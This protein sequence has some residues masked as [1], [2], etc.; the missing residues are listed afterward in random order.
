MPAK[1]DSPNRRRSIAVPNQN[2]PAFISRSKRRAHSIVSGDRLSPLARARRSLAPRKSILKASINNV[3]IN[4]SQQASQS[5]TQSSQSLNP[6]DPNT[7]QA[8]D[9]TM[10]LQS[11]QDN[12]IQRSFARRVSF[13]AHATVRLFQKQNH[14]DNTNSTGTPPSSPSSPSANEHGEPSRTPH[15]NDENDYPGARPNGRRSSL[16]YSIAQNEDMDLT[17]IGP[18]NFDQEG[19]AIMDEEIEEDSFADDT[20]AI[21]NVL[22]RRRSSVA[23][24]QFM[25]PPDN[26]DVSVTDEV[27][28]SDDAERSRNQSMEF[29]IPINRP[30]RPA[31]RDEAWLALRRVT[32]SGSENI[33]DDADM[34]ISFGHNAQEDSYNDDDASCN[35]DDENQTMNITKVL[36]WPEDK[37]RLS[38]G[39]ES[40]ME[41]SEVYGPAIPA[42]ETGPRP[43]VAAPFDPQLSSPQQEGRTSI[44]PR[45]EQ[46]PPATPRPSVFQPP[47]NDTSSGPAQTINNKIQDTF[48]PQDSRPFSFTAPSPVIAR[49]SSPSKIPV[50]RPT[51]TAAFAPPVSKSTPKKSAT[52]TAP[53]SPSHSNKRPRP[54]DDDGTAGEAD[55]SIDTPS[56][57]KR[58][59]MTSKWPGSESSPTRAAASPSIASVPKPKPLSPSKKAP[60][61]G[62][63][64]MASSSTR[65]TTSLRRPSGYFARRKSLAAG[66]TPQ[67]ASDISASSDPKS[68]NNNQPSAG[69]KTGLGFRR[70]SVSSGSTDAWQRFDKN[71]L[72]V[73]GDRPY[74]RPATQHR[75]ENASE[76]QSTSPTGMENQAALA[77]PTSQSSAVSSS[78]PKADIERQHHALS[79]PSE[80]VQSVQQ[81]VSVDLSN[82][83]DDD[84]ANEAN[85]EVVETANVDADA[86]TGH[87][88]EILDNKIPVEEETPAIS[89]EQFFATTGIRF[90]DQLTAPRR[91][92]HHS[93]YPARQVREE[94]DISLTEYFTA[95][96][97]DVP[98]LEL[99]TRVARDL[100]AWMEQSRTV[101]EQAEEE[102]AKITPELF[103]EYARADEESQVE[104]LHQLN[105][106]R[107]NV[108]GQAKSDWYDWKLQWVQGLKNIADK[109]FNALEDD[110]KIL[111]SIK[112]KADEIVPSLE[113]EYENI[114]RE[115]EQERTEVAEIEAS[116]QEYLNELKNA[117]SEQN[118]EVEALQAE[119]AEGR[120]RLQRLEERLEEIENQKSEAST[121]IAGAQR[122]LL[123]HK[124]STRAEV[125]RLKDELDALE[126][127]HMFRAT[128]ISPELFQYI[129]NSQFQVTIP[130]RNYIPIVTQ[131]DISRTKNLRPQSKD[132]FPRLSDFFL[133]MA[134]QQIVEGED[135]TVKQ[136]VHRLADY[137]SSCTQ[138][139]S[140][141]KLLSIKYPI[142]I[143]I[144]RPVN[145]E[146]LPSFKAHAT[147]LF[148]TVKAKAIISFVFSTA[149]FCF[150]PL[151]LDSMD[152][153]VKVAY[154]SI[155]QSNILKRVVDRFSQATPGNNHAC[156]LDACIEAQEAYNSQNDL[157]IP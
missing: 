18:I 46:L 61:Q 149:T 75:N 10:N 52:Q 143:E 155:D 68:I 108:R 111:E 76:N 114:M 151:T 40:N 72:P 7:T 105:L 101:Y 62:A 156:L 98:Q 83:L 13:A 90:M 41:E 97:I 148:P 120:S 118:I 39:E 66:I 117:I 42:P 70:A 14:D 30:L 79:V 104:L 43:S 65:A 82:I 146:G 56:P 55:M 93:Q 95:T 131:L 96:A 100:E 69:V 32:H 31:H 28:S 19:S 139:R 63:P 102:A 147:V 44:E 64:S 11:Q 74:S 1:R 137:W 3:N 6:D 157:R 67:S 124:S 130:C 125:F 110:A 135:L 116:D 4:P 16:R 59:A 112:A 154:G 88:A 84:A 86:D 37:S 29:T 140:Q 26:E 115:L 122:V 5:S 48:V 127:L 34:S 150:W 47:P 134:K 36:G 21:S 109:A 53:S 51:F 145:G 103:I 136:I 33:G 58:Q 119:L 123:V 133:D 22:K 132:D 57:V 106:I 126:D 73:Q 129:D 54:V 35:V 78:T 128:R 85:A 138:L 144:I 152:C 92:M 80:F 141:L 27:H 94:K 99:H 23:P 113:Q 87:W 121:A 107:T 38:I 17:S 24:S 49:P 71:A 8:M 142:N 25:Q 50:F 89:I 20:D 81:V 77:Q 12:T 91:S 60:F 9:L 153:E 2:K 45:P 15:F